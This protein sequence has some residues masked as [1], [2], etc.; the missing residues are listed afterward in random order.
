MRLLQSNLKDEPEIELQPRERLQT[1]PMHKA[2]QFD[3]ASLIKDLR[4]SI[5]E[6]EGDTGSPVQ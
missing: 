6:V 5:L 2:G 1:I 4:D 3:W